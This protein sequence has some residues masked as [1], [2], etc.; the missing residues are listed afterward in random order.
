MESFR[1]NT[2]KEERLETVGSVLNIIQKFRQAQAGGQA[3]KKALEM[4]IEQIPLVSN[5]WSLIKNTKEAK[6][7]ISTLYGLDD[8]FKSNTG[9]D[10]LNVD[11]NISKIVDD[12]IETA[13]LNFLIDKL[14]KMDPEAPMPDATAE[15]Q[16]FLANKFNQHTVKK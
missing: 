7:M 13:F 15:I 12:K 4:T 2:L 10:K 14:G 1:R 16:D 3:G 11:D 5:I 8:N 6:D 9:L